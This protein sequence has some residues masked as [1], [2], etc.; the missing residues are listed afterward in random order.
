MLGCWGN[1]AKQPE[2]KL[3]ALIVARFPPR[4]NP[5]QD[6]TGIKNIMINSFEKFESLQGFKKVSGGWQAC[7]PAHDDGNASLSIGQGEGGKIVLF[8]HAGCSVSDIVGA[9]GIK[10]RD[11][12]P[13]DNHVDTGFRGSQHRQNDRRQTNG[14][15]K[16]KQPNAPKQQQKRRIVAEYPY[17]SADRTLLYQVL[18]Y[19]P[20]DFRQRAPDGSGGWKWSMKGVRRVLYNLPLLKDNP[21]ARVF[22]VEGEKDANRLCELGLIATTCAQGAGKW[23]ASFSKTLAR[24]DVVILPDNDKAGTKHAAT[25][26]DS[27]HSNDCNVRVVSLP[28]GEKGDISDYLDSGNSIVDLSELVEETEFYIPVGELSEDKGK[29]TDTPY[30]K[31]QKIINDLDSLNYDLRLNTLEDN[32][33]LGGRRIDDVM[34]SEINLRMTD[35]D[36]SRADTAD[37][38]NVLGA[39]KRY[40]PIRDYL[41]GLKWDGNSR[42]QEMLDCFKVGDNGITFQNKK[43]KKCYLHHALMVR[44]L[45]G[46]VARGIGNGENEAFTHQ[47]P[48]LVLIGPQGLGKSSW[49]RW[50]VSGVGFEFHRE[51]PIDPHNKDDLR[52]FVVKWIWEAS[53]LAASL[54][55]RDRDSLK[56]IITQEH[57]TY[58][59]PYGKHPI[60]KPTLCSLVGTINPETGFLDDPTGHRRFLPATISDIDHSYGKLDIDQVWAELVHMYKNGVS[61][62]LSRPEYDALQSSYTDHKIDNPLETYIDM[63]FDIDAGNAKKRT[64]TAEII[65]RL[66][67]F[68]VSLPASVKVAGQ[69]IGEVLS[70]LGCE[71]KRFMKSKTNTWGWIGIEPNN[72]EPPFK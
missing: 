50:L 57:H 19:E 56:S 46:A 17:T 21:D 20:K 27:L 35:F 67:A 42:L 29:N 12:F 3:S 25:V 45:I 34:L 40:H 15:G 9:M 11:L 70:P 39:R 60:T 61:P 63:Y 14:S 52:S 26:A 23:Q 48:M 7:C 69:H 2:E 62:E 51:S 28:V 66:Q 10:V 8:C 16:P 5:P 31:S 65:H 37:A 72:I 44:W 41:N 4:R 71:R 22:I 64:H 38:I 47:N 30:L 32:V 6:N 59:K 13:T 1:R 49:V 43:G 53:E 36:H 54:R 24:R 18:R 55:R 58:R 68:G 33:E